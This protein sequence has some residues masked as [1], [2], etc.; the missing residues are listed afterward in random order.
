MTDA[1]LL[2][3][4]RGIADVKLNRP[5][6]YNALN[7]EIFEGLLAAGAA[8]RKDPSVRVVL[9]SGVGRGFCSGLDMS[10]FGDMLGGEL[11]AEGVADAYDDLSPAGANRAQQ[12]GWQ[13]QELPVPVIAAIHG[14]A[15][16]G[17][18]NVAL[19][20][21][22]RI[23]APDAKLG[24]VE[25]TWGLLPDMGA[26]QA[27]RRLVPLDR[28]MELVLSGRILRGDEAVAAGLATRL[29]ETPYEDARALA[30][31]MARHNPD[32]LRRGKRLLAGSAFTSV[33][34]GLIAESN[35]SREM[36]GTPNQLEAVKA[37]LEGREPR[38]EIA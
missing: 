28:A 4:D 22:I 35:A 7:D 14:A 37:R 10:N 15:M 1:V 29:S 24:F 2:T 9:L 32:A 8:I 25:I 31:Q 3:T 23:V 38:F 27:L 16:G 33:R 18:L 17:G 34:E 13:F 12:L 36:L 26:T 11:T 20:A 21:D 5:E 6:A 30:E 19:G